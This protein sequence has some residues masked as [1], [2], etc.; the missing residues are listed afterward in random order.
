M[1]MA[2]DEELSTISQLFLVLNAD[3][4][5]AGHNGF[6]WTDDEFTQVNLFLSAIQ[7]AWMYKA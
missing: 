4:K 3:P 7:H 2:K 5:V 6:V 1:G